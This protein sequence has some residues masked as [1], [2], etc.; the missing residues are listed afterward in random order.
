MTPGDQRRAAGACIDDRDRSFEAREVDSSHQP[1]RA[2]PND[3]GVK[4]LSHQKTARHKTKIAH[5]NCV[6][7]VILTEHAP[8]NVR[9]RLA[10][11]PCTI[12]WAVV[13]G[14]RDVRPCCYRA[15]CPCPDRRYRPGLPRS[16][17]R[18][19]SGWIPP[20]CPAPRADLRSLPRDPLWLIRDRLEKRSQQT[21]R[22]WKVRR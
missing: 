7:G 8:N 10:A 17:F 11:P 14:R 12:C 21:P 5:P 3:D 15:S 6:M 20:C 19:H 4:H 16:T 22:C 2:G 9:D 1:C 13:A 18:F